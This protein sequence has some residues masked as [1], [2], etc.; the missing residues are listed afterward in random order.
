MG[1]KIVTFGEMLLRLTTPGNLRLQQVRSFDANFGG[2]EVNVAVSI[3]AY[4]GE[5]ALVTAL[6]DNPLGKVCLMKLREHKVCTHD[7]MMVEGGRLGMYIV[8][9]AADLRP[10]SVIYDRNDSA[11]SKLEPGMIDWEEALRGADIFH[12]S[13]IN[14][15]LTRG[16]ADVCR[17]AISVAGRMGVKVSCDINYRKNLWRYGRSAEEVLVPLMQSSDIIFGS[18]G[19]YE[20]A[21][22]FKA[23][24]FNVK[25]R[26]ERID[27]H[28]YEDYCS[29]V[30]E[31]LPRCK[32]LFMCMRN[33]ITP[34]HHCLEGVLYAGGGMKVSR[35][36]EVNNVVDSMGVGDAFVGAMLYAV[37]NYADDQ[38]KLDFAMAGSALKNT[39][40]G[41]YNIVSADEVEALMTGGSAEM[42][43]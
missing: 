31:R 3:A 37:Q 40:V 21:L 15:S 17:E 30:S 34:E 23:P 38:K 32:H 26:A 4:G 12:W 9:K 28:E 22:G 41:D 35:T 14:A 36:Y 43:R 42:R 20:K 5:S 19:E 29:R 1:K 25:S 24:A 13:G 33:A 6:P 11:F 39:I 16:L 2:S 18:S 10:A 8:E 27:A 7:V